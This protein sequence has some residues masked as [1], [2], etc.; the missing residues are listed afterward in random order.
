[1]ETGGSINDGVEMNFIAYIILIFILSDYALH[2][3]ADGLNLRNLN[4]GVPDPFKGYFD[5]AEYRKSI[6][7]LKIN[8]RFEWI[9]S[10]SSLLLMLGFWFGGGFAFWD[11]WVRAIDKGSIVSGLIYIGGLVLLKS[12]FNLPFKIY[13]TFVIEEK[14]GFNK[15]TWP[16]FVA[17][18]FKILILSILIGLPVL[19][20]ILWFFQA[21]GEKAWLYCWGTMTGFM[22]MVQFV[23]PRWIMPLFNKF[24]PIEE[25]EL[26]SKIMAYAR[27]IKFPLENVYVMDGSK[28]SDKSNAFFTG[29]GK[30]K[31]IVLFDTL[32]KGHT[33]SELLAVLAHEMG[34]YKMRHIQKMMLAGILQMG[35]L[36]YLLSYFI[37]YQ[38]LFDA[39][40]LNQPSVYGGMVFFGML[41]SPMDFFIGLIFQIFSRKHEFQAD[42]FAVQTIDEPYALVDALKKLSVNNLSNLMPH[43]LYVF[44]NYSHPPVLD[45]INFINLTIK[46]SSQSPNSGGYAAI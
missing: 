3:L 8:T 9:Y 13:G 12:I 30:N 27:E 46:N 37:S 36:F 25:G 38:P 29:F 34:H 31:R 2:L 35:L 32:I 19:F 43:P 14:F 6:Q 5:E 28:R 45:R 42:R 22:L 41:Y 39:F 40:Y 33:A 20:A 7:Y 21:A 17:D 23:A 18:V 15:T 4:E 26:K 11:Q 1:L 16:T 10:T 24:E 44:L